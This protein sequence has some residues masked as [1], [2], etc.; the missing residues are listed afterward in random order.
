MQ[1]LR[2]IG[3]HRDWLSGLTKPT[4]AGLCLDIKDFTIYQ[5][6]YV[7]YIMCDIY[8]GF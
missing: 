8:I 3:G 2:H 5:L 4:S 1:K 7:G 6:G